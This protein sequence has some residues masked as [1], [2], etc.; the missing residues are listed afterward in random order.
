MFEKYMK[1]RQEEQLDTILQVSKSVYL[2]KVLY[3][4]KFELFMYL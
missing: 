2:G 1:Y 3:F 4:D